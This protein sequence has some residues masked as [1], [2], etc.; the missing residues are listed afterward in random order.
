MK[1]QN[2][3]LINKFCNGRTH[4]RT[5][6]PKAICPFNF[7]KI[8]GMNSEKLQEFEKSNASLQI[9]IVSKGSVET[10]GFASINF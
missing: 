4:G 3:I 2:C 10:L 6:K 9:I 5:D 7:S 1:F 8:E